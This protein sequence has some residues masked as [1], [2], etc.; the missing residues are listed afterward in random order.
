MLAEAYFPSRMLCIVRLRQPQCSDAVRQWLWQ[1][2]FDVSGL[3]QSC[4]LVELA[5]TSIIIVLMV[6]CVCSVLDMLRIILL[7]RPLFKWIGD[8]KE[9]I[10]QDFKKRTRRL[11][12]LIDKYLLFKNAPFDLNHLNNSITQSMREMIFLPKRYMPRG[13]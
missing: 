6:F 1:D 5:I 11:D 10:E 8:H 4:N 12:V 3:Y 2:V 7:E 9:A 13:R